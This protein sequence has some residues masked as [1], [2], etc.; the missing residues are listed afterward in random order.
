MTNLPVAIVGFVY[1]VVMVSG[2]GGLS[3]TAIGVPLL[4]GGLFLSRQLG[5]LD[6]ARARALLGVRV[7]EPT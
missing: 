3:V 5:R 1:T 6:R 2:T 4:A 7:D